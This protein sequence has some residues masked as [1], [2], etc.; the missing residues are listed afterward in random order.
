VIVLPFPSSILAGHANSNGHH[1]KITATKKHR[2]WAKDATQAAM[3]LKPVIPAGDI[4]VTVMFYPP[5][6]LGDR[7]NFP[8]RMKPYFDGIADALKV[9]D[10][11]FVPVFRFMAPEKPG[12]V[13]VE[14]GV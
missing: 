5:N 2:E 13:E 12:R 9:N 3:G 10:K 4:V 7:I 1:A 11:R 6:N 14:I 8:N